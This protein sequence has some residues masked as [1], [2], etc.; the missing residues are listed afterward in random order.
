MLKG[1]LLS[2][3]ICTTVLF[4][5]LILLVMIPNLPLKFVYAVT[6]VDAGFMLIAFCDYIV[7][8]FA[9]ESDF[10]AIDNIDE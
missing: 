10:Q 8:Y 3:K 2:G 7:S 6:L 4:I 5:S 9:R 1:A